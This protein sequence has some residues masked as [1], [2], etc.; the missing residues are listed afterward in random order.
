MQAVMTV[1]AQHHTEGMFVTEAVHFSCLTYLSSAA[2]M[3]PTYKVIKPHLDFVL[4]QIIFPVL[5][6][7]VDEIR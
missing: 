5:C 3:S 1:L 4:G 7:N 2:E 6:I